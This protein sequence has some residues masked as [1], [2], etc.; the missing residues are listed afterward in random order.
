MIFYLKKI[1]VT[2]SSFSVSTLLKRFYICHNFVVN[3]A[4][5][6]IISMYVHLIY[7]NLEN[8]L[9]ISLCRYNLGE[10]RFAIFKWLACSVL[11]LS[12]VEVI[13]DGLNF[14]MANFLE[15]FVVPV[16]SVA[17]DLHVISY[18][19]K[20]LGCSVGTTHDFFNIETPSSQE[21]D[22]V[23]LYKGRKPGGWCYKTVGGILCLYAF[24]VIAHSAG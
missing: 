14:P 22:A 15:N 17:K 11:C 13:S 12:A 21:E 10:I 8:F 1:F 20:D 9:L 7:L 16:D 24:Y 5:G 18:S 19:T 2:L 6:T 3:R 4:Y 23:E